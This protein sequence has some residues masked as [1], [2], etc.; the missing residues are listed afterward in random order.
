MELV[1]SW[2]KSGLLFGILGSVIIMLV[3]SKTYIKHIGMVIGLI[4][5]LV[6]LRPV[7]SFLEM[8]GNMYSSFV[9]SFLMVEGETEVIPDE[10]IEMYEDAVNI[11]LMTVLKEHGYGV[12]SIKVKACEDG[13]VENVTV[14]FEGD[15]KDLE[16]I[17]LYLKQVLGEEVDICYENE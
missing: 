2:V 7:I 14:V 15:V 5:I 10:D 17:E 8:D 3:P 11:Q 9:K 16:C 1:L 4:F 12:K 6:M 13:T